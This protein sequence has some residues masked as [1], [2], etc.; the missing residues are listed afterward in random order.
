MKIEMNNMVAGLAVL[1]VSATAAAAE[2]SLTLNLGLDDAKVHSATYD[3]ATAGDIDVHYFTSDNNTLAVVPVGDDDR[4]FVNV[5]AASG[6]RYVAGA[7]EWWSS[8]QGATLRN[9]LTDETL[10]SCQ[11]KDQ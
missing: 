4:I 5:V 10:L 6:S 9:T 7:Y 11:P 8:A 2:V 1:V 3:C